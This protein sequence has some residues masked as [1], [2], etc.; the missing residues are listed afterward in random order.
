[1]AVTIQQQPQLYTPVYNPMRFVLSSTN[2]AQD[3]FKYVAD[4]YV[5][6]VSGYERFLYDTDPTYGTAAADVSRVLESHLSYNLNE[7]TDGFIQC[8]N[9]IIGYEVKFGEQYGPSSGIV[10]YSNLTVTG[11]KYAW[12]SVFDTPTFRTFNYTLYTPSGG[13]AILSDM[14]A[15][16]YF[17]SSS[18]HSYQYLLN[19]TSG[20]VYFAKI[21]TYDTSNNLLGTYLIENSYQASSAI[22]DKLIRIDVGQQSLNSVTLYSGVQPVITASVNKYTVEMTNFAGSSTTDQYT[23]TRECT[24]HSTTPID[25]YFLNRK[26]GF[27]NF[28]FKMQ[29]TQFSDIKRDTLQKNL[30][31]LTATTWSYASSDRGTTVFNTKINDR[32]KLES[33]WIDDAQSIWLQQ[34]VESP[35]VY[36]H[37]GSR[38]HPVVIKNNSYEI[39]TI[40]N[41]EKLFNLSVEI[42]FANERWTQRG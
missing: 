15:G 22:A 35:E 20:S 25:L 38:M 16:Q 33:D 13:S 14:P 23:Y 24:W 36:Y 2:T 17:N 8:T 21:Q 11:L 18:T 5:S 29:R 41:M 27:D 32:W 30:G 34:L 26:G 19:D 9:S 42:E 28:T 6:G 7:T 31:S 39:K 1:M 12:N 40:K 3:N 4:V 37:I 10:T